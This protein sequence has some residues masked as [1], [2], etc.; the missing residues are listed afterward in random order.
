MEAGS[1]RE[2]FDTK[3]YLPVSTGWKTS[4]PIPKPGPG[5]LRMNGSSSSTTGSEGS[6]ASKT[7]CCCVP[8]PPGRV[9]VLEWEWACHCAG[10]IRVIFVTFDRESS[11]S[12]N[13]IPSGHD[14]Q[15]KATSRL[16]AQTPT[17]K[18]TKFKVDGSFPL[19]TNLVTRGFSLDSIHKQSV[20]RD[21]ISSFVVLG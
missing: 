5:R 7:L 12:R 16:F 8:D 3:R 17:L 21:A 19:G 20:T 1:G 10:P 11:N 2:N 13:C 14:S 4:S 6:E 9:P 15:E 18:E